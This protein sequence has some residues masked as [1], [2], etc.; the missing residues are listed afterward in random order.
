MPLYMWLYEYQLLP[1]YSAMCHFDEHVHAAVDLIARGKKS[2]RK[3]ASFNRGM[4]SAGDYTTRRDIIIYNAA[5]IVR[6]MP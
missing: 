2:S 4:Q 5:A 1:I 3:M 6:G